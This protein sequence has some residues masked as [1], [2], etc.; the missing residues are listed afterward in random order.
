MSLAQEKEL[1]A[2]AEARGVDTCV[3]EAWVRGR[4]WIK[5]FRAVQRVSRRR[6]AGPAP[7]VQL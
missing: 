6:G 7:G 1:E 2:R 4:A 5:L 3:T